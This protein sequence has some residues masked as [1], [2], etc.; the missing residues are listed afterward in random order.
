VT[1]TAGNTLGTAYITVKVADTR[2][3]NSGG[4]VMIT[5]R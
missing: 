5:V 1:F 3:G 4:Y 2:G